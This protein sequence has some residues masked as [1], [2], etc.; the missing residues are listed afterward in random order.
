MHYGE[1]YVVLSLPF[2]IPIN[3]NVEISPALRVRVK[4]YRRYPPA[5]E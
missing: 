1:L 2:V 4:F 5:D 3:I